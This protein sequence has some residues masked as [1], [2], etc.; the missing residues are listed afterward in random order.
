MATKGYNLEQTGEQVQAALNKAIN[1]GPATEEADGLMTSTDKASLEHLNSVIDTKVDKV[2]GKGLST[3]DFTNEDK[4]KLDTAYQV[5]STGIPAADMSSGVQTSLGKA[6]SAVQPADL[7]PITEKIPAQASAQNQLADKAFVNSSISTASADFKGTYDSLAELQAVTADKNDYGYVVSTDE[8]GNTVYS[9]Y[10]YNGSSWVFEYDLNNSSFTAAEWAAIQSGITAPLVQKLGALPTNA[11]LQSAL[12]GKQATLVSGTNIKT[13]DGQS[14]LGSGNLSVSDPNAVKVTAQ[15]WTDAQKTQARTN[16]G[17]YAKPSGGIPKA[18]L[19]SGVQGSLDLADSAIQ[20]RPSGE[21]DPTITPADYATQEELAQL[22]AKVSGDKYSTGKDMTTPASGAM[23]FGSFNIDVDIPAGKAFNIL[24]DGETQ[25]ISDAEFMLWFDDSTSWAQPTTHISFGTAYNVQAQAKKVTKI[26]LYVSSNNITARET[27]FNLSVYYDNGAGIVAELSELDTKVDGVV[28]RVNGI[29]ID[30]DG[31][32]V[33]KYMTTPN[34]GGIVYSDFN[35]ETD[36]PSGKSF[37][38]LVGSESAVFASANVSLWFSDT[39]SWDAGNI[40]V[41]LNVPYSVPAQAK[42]VKKVGIYVGEQNILIKNASFKITVS[43]E[44]GLKEN[45]ENLDERVTELEEH[46]TFK[47]SVVPTSAQV[48]SKHFITKPNGEVSIEANGYYCTD[49]LEVPFKSGTQIEF[50]SAVRG[51]VAAGFYDSEKNIIRVMSVDSADYESA[52]GT[53][54]TPTIQTF[55]LAL[56]SGTK[57]IRLSA[58]SDYSSPSDFYIKGD[59]VTTDEIVSLKETVED[60][61]IPCFAPF[62][63]DM[64][65]LVIGDSI[66]TGT[67]SAK[68]SASF[69]SYGNYDKWVDDLIKVGY[70]PTDAVNDSQHA[71]GF[72]AT[73]GTITYGGVTYNTDFLSRVKLIEA[74]GYD[75]STFD[76]IIVF[77]GVN[78]F[79]LPVPLGESGD[80][81]TTEFIPAL[82]EFYAYL[83]DKATQARICTLLPMETSLVITNQLGLKIEDYCEAIKDVIGKYRLPYLDLLTQS[84]FCP[85]VAKFRAMWTLDW[86]SSGTGDGLHPNEEYQEKY[87]TPQIRGFIEGII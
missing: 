13:V 7:V 18:D 82:E 40:D 79:K 64:K 15:T 9:R 83:L 22:E 5:P 45:I 4:S 74:M 6:N 53:A 31:Y 57:Y 75:L 46:G 50:K 3:N 35:I 61:I 85:T 29:E 19:A 72:V 59:I 16:I 86:D 67:S 42:T 54:D 77:G 63:K 27:D 34:T 71:T 37:S 25:V 24:L 76:L 36:I 41:S 8:A 68:L 65:V 81:D 26:G 47:Y 39:E 38:I 51:Y 14:I 17:A 56:P 78:D 84:G 60:N 2:T 10:K 87:L 12:S 33:D 52:G 80:S 28:E 49:F 70:F 43:C 1:L 58:G 21:V 30:L 11:D 73:N 23:Y 55:V 32:S 48:I 20:A 66:S 62:V 44:Q 69:P